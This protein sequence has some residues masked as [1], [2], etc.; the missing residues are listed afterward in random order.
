MAR[1]TCVPAVL[2]VNSMKCAITGNRSK[3]DQ[4]NCLIPSTGLLSWIAFA[5]PAASGSTPVE[6]MGLTWA[7]NPHNICASKMCINDVDQVRDVHMTIEN[8]RNS[9][10]RPT[11]RAVNLTASAPLLDEAKALGLN[12]SRMFESSLENA[13][14]AARQEAWLAANREAIEAY[15]EQVER[16]GVF[17]DGLRSF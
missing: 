16:H 7:M 1:I 13:V 4:S 9:A 10:T 3:S 12:L 8:S 11:K 6:R 15:N 2:R 5:S 17:S 14:R